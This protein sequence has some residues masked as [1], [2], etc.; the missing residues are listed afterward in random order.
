MLVVV[1]VA[2]AEADVAAPV[3]V[4]P[5]VVA[6]T[7]SE[8]GKVSR[9]AAAALLPVQTSM[10]K[11]IGSASFPLIFPPR[12]KQKTTSPLVVAL[13]LG[14]SVRGG[15]QRHSFRCSAS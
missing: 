2:V 9:A 1:A 4:A 8:R 10:V 13:T 15:R 14:W 12:V 5:P 7:Q 11:A 6:S 3:A